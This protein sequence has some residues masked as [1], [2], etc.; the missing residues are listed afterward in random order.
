MLTVEA[1]AYFNDSRADLA[2]AIGVKVPSVYCWKKYPP[3]LRQ[4]QLEKI[5][6]GQLKAEPGVFE[7]RRKDKEAA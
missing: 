5:T 6:R 3:P 2:R 4:I 1:L 7:S